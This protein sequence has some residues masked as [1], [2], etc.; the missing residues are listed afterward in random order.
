[1][2]AAYFS[3][4]GNGN[5]ATDCAKKKAGQKPAHLY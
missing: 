4:R 5:Q 2:G 3:N 1:M